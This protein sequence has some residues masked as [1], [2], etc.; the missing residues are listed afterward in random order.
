M[1]VNIVRGWL[2][3]NFFGFFNKFMN[4]F[5]KKILFNGGVVVK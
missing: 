1:F 3:S 4:F 5:F 2:N